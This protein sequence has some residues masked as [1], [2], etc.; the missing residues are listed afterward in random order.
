MRRHAQVDRVKRLSVF[1]EKSAAVRTPDFGA[2]GVV[3]ENTGVA[4][5]CLGWRQP[6]VRVSGKI[7]VGKIGVT[8]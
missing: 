2:R 5:G 6:E 7:G 8:H 3:A 1:R 4:A